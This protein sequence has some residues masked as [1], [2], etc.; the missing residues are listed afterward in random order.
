[1]KLVTK[2]NERISIY[3]DENQFIVKVRSKP[4]QRFDK[5]ETWYFPTLDMCFQE[6]FEYLCRKKLADGKN[7]NLKEVA[8][9]IL[10]TREEL[11]KIMELLLG[12]DPE[13]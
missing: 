2:I 13:F 10:K 11:L 12:L 3:A 8:K 7:K 4:N 6:I 5:Q 1:M 9:I